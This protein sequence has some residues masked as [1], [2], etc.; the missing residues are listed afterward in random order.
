M[1]APHRYSRPAE[2][3][4]KMKFPGPERIGHHLHIRIDSAQI[5]TIMSLMKT[6]PAST[7]FQIANPR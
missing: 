4:V 3:K 7:A 2:E 6:L 5:N 1:I